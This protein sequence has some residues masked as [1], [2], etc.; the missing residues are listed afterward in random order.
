LNNLEEKIKTENNKEKNSS[1][2]KE[3]RKS[4]R[5]KS[6]E[7]NSKIIKDNNINKVLK[8]IKSCNNFH[9]VMNSLVIMN[10]STNNKNSN[11]KNRPRRTHFSNNNESWQD[12]S[13]IIKKRKSYLNNSTF[14]ESLLKETHPDNLRKSLMRKNIISDINQVIIE[15][16]ENII[17]KKEKWKSL[18]FSLSFSDDDNNE[19]N[20]SNESDDNISKVDSRQLSMFDEDGIKFLKELKMIGSNYVYKGK[21]KSSE[22]NDNNKD[23]ESKFKNPIITNFAFNTEIN[24]NKKEEKSNEKKEENDLEQ[25]Y[26][27]IKSDSNN[28]NN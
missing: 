11:I 19:D 8:K 15:E 3:K 4:I 2:E 22:N 26:S 16:K 6:P 24:E 18:R 20:L 21:K 5:G 25:I 28:E 13:I 17:N 12:T 1:N 7:Q 23:N 27:T 9:K 10:Q 14:F